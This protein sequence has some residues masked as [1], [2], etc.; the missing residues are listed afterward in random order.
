MP[1]VIHNEAYSTPREVT[2]TW[3]RGTNA[4]KLLFS[5]AESQAL[6]V[7]ARMEGAGAA[8]GAAGG[9]GDE[10]LLGPDSATIP[11]EVSDEMWQARV[12]CRCSLRG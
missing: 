11:L 4:A 5:G 8:A 12:L 1:H 3:L 6:E 10:S 2:D 9:R 7:L